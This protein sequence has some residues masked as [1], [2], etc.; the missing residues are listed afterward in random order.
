L[1]QQSLTNP[2]MSRLQ[3]FLLDALADPGNN[4]IYNKAVK[5]ANS[6]SVE[7]VRIF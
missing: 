1:Q 5:I 7:N 6:S 4:E 3:T 2:E